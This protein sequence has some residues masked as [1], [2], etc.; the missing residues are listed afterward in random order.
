MRFQCVRDG[1]LLIRVFCGNH[2]RECAYIVL[3]IRGLQAEIEFPSDWHEHRA[4]WIRL[5]FGFGKLAF[6][7][8]WSKVVADDGQCSG[9]T[10]GFNFF[11]DGLHVHW[12]KQHGRRGDPFTIIPM[13]W[14]WRHRKHEV[15]T[16]PETHPYRYVTRSGE[17]QERLA[18]INVE[19]RLWIRPWIPFRRLSRYI[20]IEFDKEVGERSGSW[21]GGVLGCSEAMRQGET[22]ADTLRR[23]ERD[24]VFT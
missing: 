4:G 18:K 17:V 16:T 2:W 5:G 22:P 19:T 1:G 3:G 24:R 8:P 14:Q 15:L 7:F 12:G 9:P 10:Y 21:K 13:P 20:N 6:S 11:G 23:M